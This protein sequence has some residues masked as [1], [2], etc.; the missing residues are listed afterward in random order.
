MGY[1]RRSVFCHDAIFG[2]FD[3]D[4][5]PFAFARIFVL[6]QSRLFRRTIASIRPLV[7]KPN[8]CL[9]PRATNAIF[10]SDRKLQVTQAETNQTA[11]LFLRN[12][13]GRDILV[14]GLINMATLGLFAF[15]ILAMG[16]YFHFYYIDDI[17][18]DEQTARDYSIVIPNPPQNAFDPNEW[19]RY[20]Q[21]ELQD[22]ET[23]KGS[24][25]FREC[26]VRCCTV[27]I[28][29]GL[30]LRS[31]VQRREVLQQIVGKIE[32]PGTS[33][34]IGNLARKAAYEEKG[35]KFLGRQLAKFMPG[36]KYILQNFSQAQSQV[37]LMLN[38][39]LLSQVP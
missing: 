12:D 31:L 23:C 1:W 20:F 26:R 15:G 3:L 9:V 4:R 11:I 39:S 13:C 38:I 24:D 36:V 19:K 8:G 16:L 27:A 7:R 21:G 37:S 34:D 22:T 6:F 17:D 30:L 32:E 2:L 25:Q 5:R 28:D 18:Q 10:R 33:I 14:P 35:R 29:N